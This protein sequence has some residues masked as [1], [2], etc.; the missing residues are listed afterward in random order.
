MDDARLSQFR[1]EIPRGLVIKWIGWV[2]ES[3][4]SK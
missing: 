2:R 1:F 3:I 4:L